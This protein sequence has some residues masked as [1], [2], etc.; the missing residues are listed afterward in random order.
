MQASAWEAVAGN[1]GGGQHGPHSETLSQINKRK[2]FSSYELCCHESYTPGLIPQGRAPSL[3]SHKCS[4]EC[5]V[6]QP[7]SLSC[8]GTGGGAEPH[9]DKGGPWSPDGPHQ[10]QGTPEHSRGPWICFCSAGDRTQGLAHLRSPTTEPQ[11]WPREM[12]MLTRDAAWCS[13]AVGTTTLTG[14]GRREAASCVG[15]QR[16]LS[17]WQCPGSQGRAKW[18][19]Q[20]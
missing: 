4:L 10:A 5:R 12:R 9:R 16:L 19:K 18:S 2:R 15:A 3:A 8:E 7:L 1:G 17:G 13:L 14:R 20:Q 6:T 11:P